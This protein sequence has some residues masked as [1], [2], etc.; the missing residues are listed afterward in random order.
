[1]QN[2][3]RNPWDARLVQWMSR[4]SETAE[5]RGWTPKAR[6]AYAVIYVILA[7]I[8][9]GAFFYIMAGALVVLALV[10]GVREYKQRHASQ[11]RDRIDRICSTVSL[12]PM[13]HAAAATASFS[14]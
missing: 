3:G 8:Y 12:I 2:N 6:A 1:M 4:G 13:L 7:I 11:A 10:L 14:R 9:G 5:S